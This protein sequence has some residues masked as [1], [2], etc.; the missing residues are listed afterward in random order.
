MNCLEKIRPPRSKGPK[1]M[2]E[3]YLKIIIFK[4]LFSAEVI[5]NE[6]FCGL[7]HFIQS[8]YVGKL[9]IYNITLFNLPFLWY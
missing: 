4:M 7:K 2:Y 8:T 3:G 1:A 6:I 5:H 9:R